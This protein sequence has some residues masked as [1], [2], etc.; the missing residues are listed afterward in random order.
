[1]RANVN[2][3]QERYEDALTDFNRVLEL[4]PTTY[5]AVLG[6]AQV[7]TEL[8][9]YE[10]AASDYSTLIEVEPQNA[11]LYLAR[12]A[13]Y[14]QS[15]SDAEA[16]ADFMQWMFSSNPQ[17][18]QDFQVVIGQSIELELREGQVY[19]VPFEATADQVI[20]IE[21][22]GEPGAQIDPLIVLVQLGG[23]APTPIAGDDDSGGD[24]NAAI[25][26][27]TIPV[28]GVYAVLVGYSGGGSEGSVVLKLAAGGE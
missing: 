21:A 1:M 17:V 4:A 7:H 28:D 14:S 3:L 5:E 18:N 16:G 27:F 15:G 10:E 13:V 9:N 23:D 6:R 22:T 8:E 11:Q 19:A 24:F 26:D 25:L 2:I 12:G 20:N